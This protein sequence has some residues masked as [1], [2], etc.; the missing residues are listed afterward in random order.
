VGPH[1]LDRLVRSLPRTGGRP[2]P[3]PAQRAMAAATGRWPSPALRIM[4]GP[5][6]ARAASA[7]GARAFTVD[8]TI[9][10]GEEAPADDRRLL[11]HEAA[12]AA[13][14]EGAPAGPRRLARRRDP[15]EAN[16][17]AIAGAA[18]RGRSVPLLRSGHAVV[19]RDV[20]DDVREKLSYKVLL[21]WVITDDE[22][23]EALALLNTIPD[24]TFPK[25]LAKLED[26]YVTRLIDNL[27]DSAKTGPQYTRLIQALGPRGT[28]SF[29][30]DR[31]S[32]G[33][34]DWAV[35]DKDASDVFNVFANLT[36]DQ[37]NQFMATLLDEGKLDTLIANATSGDEA[38]YIRPWIA[39]VPRGEASTPKQKKI[40]RTILDETSSVATGELALGTRFNLD[41]GQISKT[42]ENL[43]AKEAEDRRP[44]RDFTLGQLRDAWG[45]LE[46]LPRQHVADNPELDKLTR[47]SADGG[48]VYFDD[49]NEASIG[50]SGDDSAF[51]GDL[52]HEVGHG[53]DA[54]LGWWPS[55]EAKKQAR[56]GWDDWGTGAAADAARAAIGASGGAIG[57]LSAADQTLV[58]AEMVKQMGSDEKDN[59]KVV[60]QLRNAIGGLPFWTAMTEVD[61]K[62]LQ[63]L[64]RKDNALRIVINNRKLN[65]PWWRKEYENQSMR[66]GNVVIQ[67]AYT[68]DWVS[69]DYRAH[70]NRVSEYQFRAPREWFAEAY[71]VY[72][73]PD[74]RGKGAKL[75]DKDPSTKTYFDKNV[76]GK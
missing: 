61:R 66:L 29:V 2:L 4:S 33:L 46:G 72:Y 30:R 13:Q 43:K 59:A 76:D 67:E 44:G 31:L 52:R 56:G 35:T 54:K 38:L 1:L 16:A 32:R 64:V 5:P 63:P 60:R 69:F 20:I 23:M 70:A 10:L 28:M 50:D 74:S 48:A 8:S 55:A 9:H 27:P 45:V 12:H 65:G 40:L 47:Y 17:D 39:S 24:A 11:V 21:D 75:A 22:A 62:R 49:T 58:V 73:D 68:G 15:L 34:F 19:Q 26:K 25:E 57:T 37:Q 53:V 14:Q 6:S 51:E 18:G 36:L 71:R 42:H 7:L 3:P 41:V